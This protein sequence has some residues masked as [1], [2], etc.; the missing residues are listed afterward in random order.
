MRV[1]LKEIRE[2]KELSH[3]EAAELS[4]ISRSYYTHIENGT[5]TPSVNVAKKIAKALK[6]RWT[7]FFKDECSLKEQNSA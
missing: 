4:G 1:W 6:F 5:K 3:D 7:L 2:S